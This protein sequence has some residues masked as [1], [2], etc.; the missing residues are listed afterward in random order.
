[1]RAPKPLSPSR[2]PALEPLPGAAGPRRC[3]RAGRR[4]GWKSRAG[5]RSGPRRHSEKRQNSKPSAQQLSSRCQ[6][7]RDVFQLHISAVEA[8]LAL[9]SAPRRA[10]RSGPAIVLD[11][12]G[13]G[14]R[15]PTEAAYHV[16][17]LSYCSASSRHPRA[18]SRKDR[19]LSRTWTWLARFSHSA[20][21]A[22]YCSALV[23]SSLGLMGVDLPNRGVR[24]ESITER[25]SP[26]VPFRAPGF[27]PASP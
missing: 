21:R 13:V 8:D 9:G 1:M 27:G 19:L 15:A 11:E 4:A 20:A 17:T 2:A 18:N 23:D 6:N 22:R 3:V 25:V 10:M 14:T 12:M 16:R 5:S 26:K 7:A 24:H